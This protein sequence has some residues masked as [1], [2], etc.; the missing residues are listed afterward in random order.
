MSNALAAFNSVK[1]KEII[2]L[3]DQLIAQAKNCA[4]P[5]TRLVIGLGR[6][7]AEVVATLKKLFTDKEVMPQFKNIERG[8]FGADIA[9]TIPSMLKEFGA[10]VYGAEY[11]PKIT[12]LLRSVLV[13]SGTASS[14][15]A[16]GM[17]VNIR[18]KESLLLQYLQ[19][20][21]GSKRSVVENI[22]ALDRH[23]VIDYSAPNVAKKLHA[24]HIRSTIIGHVLGNIHQACG[25][26]VFRLNHINDFGG[27]GFLIEGL[28]RWDKSILATMSNEEKVV[29]LYRIRRLLENIL[30]N[31]SAWDG[32]SLEEKAL[33]QSCLGTHLKDY[34]AVAG[35]VREYVKE[36]TDVFERLENG[37]E[38]EVAAWRLIVESSLADFAKFY[39][40]LNIKIDFTI[41]ESFYL[42]AGNKVIDEALTHSRALRYSPAECDADIAGYKA[43]LEAGKITE[44][45][46]AKL[47][48]EAKTD[49]G[50]I[51]VRL[52]N[53]TRLVVRRSDGRSIYATRDLGALSR[54]CDL[55]SPQDIVYVVGQEQRDHFSGFFEAGQI[56]KILG[57]V[58]P[59]LTHLYFGFYVDAVNKKKLSSREGA[60]SVMQLL[61][62]SVEYFYKKLKDA[63]FPEEE[64]RLTAKELAIASLVFNDLEK[65]MKGAVEIDTTSLLKTIEKFEKAGGA[66]VIYTAC[67]TNALKRRFKDEKEKGPIN[68]LHEPL[69]DQEVSL[70]LQLLKTS[71]VVA[72]AAA[73]NN[74][75]LLVKHLI[76]I[77]QAYS[78]YYSNFSVFTKEGVYTDRILFAAAVNRALVDGLKVCNV[79]CPARI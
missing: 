39:D 41:G 63:E 31:R 54:R 61:S 23:F 51:V 6:V 69:S 32:A 71:D 77:A 60:A 47:A 19:A 14:V 68:E 48:E 26:T 79:N 75:S 15:E 36:S 52:S 24:G 44:V 20:F 4:R 1:E 7:E 13:A 22:S 3:R 66:Y 49:I 29:E 30:E 35:A 46:F 10:K 28:K 62:D 27:F 37:G 8:S 72:Q 33:V 70:A 5:G 21:E 34:D 73:T 38:A 45:Q 76:D 78:S 40:A 42:D 56:F 64:K 25:A 50:A 58:P 11:V 53:R 17:Y 18:L 2:A 65:D 55:F 43:E 59:R 9:V 12:K 67:R 57:E 16:K 74:P